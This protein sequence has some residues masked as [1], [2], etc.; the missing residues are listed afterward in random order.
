MIK[1]KFLEENV[2]INLLDLGL[3]NSFVAKKKKKKYKSNKRKKKEI[4]NHK[5][6]K[7]LCFQKHSWPKIRQ[8]F[9][10]KKK[11]KVQKQQKKT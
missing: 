7:H 4:K 5:K 6:K 11:K 10:S 9:W 3:G 2:S 1:K 8:Q